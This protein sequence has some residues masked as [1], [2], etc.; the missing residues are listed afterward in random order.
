M[1]SIDLVSEIKRLKE[2]KNA[3]IL[4][5]YYVNGEVQE[6]ADFVGD[7]YMLSVKASETDADIIL[8]CGVRFMAETAKLL[9]PDKKVLLS[10]EGAG[11]GMADK[12]LF[13]EIKQYKE[14]NPDVKI[15]SYVNT[16][17]DIK[18]LTE[19]CVTSSNAVKVASHYKGEKLLFIPDP[20]LGNYI[21]KKLDGMN[22]DTW[23]SP[24]CVHNNRS[25]DDVLMFKE[26]Y[27]N[28]KFI[29]HPE[30]DESVWTMADFVGS[31]KQLLDFVTNDPH[32]EFIVGTEQGILHMMQKQ[33]PNKKFHVLGGR[34]LC[35]HMKKTSLQHVYNELLNEKTEIIFDQETIDKASRPL[36]K[37]LE[38]S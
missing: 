20:N 16:N 23:N 10:H 37:M 21:N 36:V 35:G 18:S 31:T 22:M 24:C 12:V 33:N 5:H 9:S 19:V 32:D 14:D 29:C 15:I 7:S 34:M 4:A 25:V 2:E 28:A 6:V 27:P 38:L 11:C 26:E 8:F 3:V 17:A 1:S 13:E 30:C